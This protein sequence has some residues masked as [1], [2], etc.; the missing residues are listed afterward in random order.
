[1]AYAWGGFI[2]LRHAAGLYSHG[3][4]GA[5]LYSYCMGRS[6]GLYSHSMGCM[7]AHTLACTRMHSH[8]DAL[9]P[10]PAARFYPIRLREDVRKGAQ[11]ISCICSQPVA[12]RKGRYTIDSEQEVDE[13]TL[14]LVFLVPGEIF[15]EVPD[16]DS[17]KGQ[18]ARMVR[19]DDT[20]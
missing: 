15:T 9:L 2:Q 1:M 18:R 8:L 10:R 6:S 3:I 7:H 16:I 11:N 12:G 20:H 17:Y 13:G 4:H 19:Y 5:G 14:I